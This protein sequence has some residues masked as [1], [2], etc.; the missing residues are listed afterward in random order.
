MKREGEG[1]GRKGEGDENGR[2]TIG[3]GMKGG[4]NLGRGWEGGEASRG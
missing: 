4:G 1:I 2:G 3:E